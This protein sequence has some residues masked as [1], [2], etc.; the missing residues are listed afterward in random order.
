MLSL[1]KAMIH[2][3]RAPLCSDCG[4]GPKLPKQSRCGDCLR[5]HRQNRTKTPVAKRKAHK[6]K[7]VAIPQE[8]I[9]TVQETT[10][11]LIDSVAMKHGHAVTL[12]AR[13]GKMSTLQIFTNPVLSFKGATQEILKRALA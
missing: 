4:E 13:P 11:C 6:V 12:V 5:R 10:E 7:I 9:V 2:S 8:K 3:K 1:L